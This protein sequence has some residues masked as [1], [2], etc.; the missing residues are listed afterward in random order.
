MKCIRNKNT[1]GIKRVSNEYASQMVDTGLWV[2]CPKQEWKHEVRDAKQ[3][4]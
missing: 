2:Y 4:K 1:K 3:G